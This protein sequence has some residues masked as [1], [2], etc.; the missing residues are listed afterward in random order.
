M[1]SPPPEHELE[2]VLPPTSPRMADSGV[3]GVY[4]HVTFTVQLCT[5][6]PLDVELI[7]GDPAAFAHEI[8][9]CSAAVTAV[10]TFV[11]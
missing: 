8:K 10:P 1:V 2:P 3:T 9:G 7:A 4:V 5:V 6:L 11:A